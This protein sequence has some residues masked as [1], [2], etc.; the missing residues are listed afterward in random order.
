MDGLKM[1]YFVLNPRSKKKNDPYAKASRA[2][3]QKYAESIC[4][5]N[6]QLYDDLKVWVTNTIADEVL[7][8][9]D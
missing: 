8:F 9:G 5:E 1:K 7:R 2:A 4:E 3:M 6:Q